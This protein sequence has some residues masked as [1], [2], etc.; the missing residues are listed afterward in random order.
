VIEWEEVVHRPGAPTVIYVR[1][2]EA[3]ALPLLR[4]AT[5]R[6]VLAAHERSFADRIAARRAYGETAVG[7]QEPFHAVAQ[8]RSGL[9]LEDLI[10]ST[11]PQRLDQ[12]SLGGRECRVDMTI[13]IG[14]TPGVRR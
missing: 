10:T 6:Q 8:L 12:V 9:L 3:N 14:P 13:R 11:R 5:D 1:P 7:A 2:S 4:R